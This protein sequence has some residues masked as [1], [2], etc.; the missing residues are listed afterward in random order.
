[1]LLLLPL[2]RFIHRCVH[3]GIFKPGLGLQSGRG[4]RTA[5][6]RV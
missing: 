4:I 2:F 5:D 1:L 3:R 6:V